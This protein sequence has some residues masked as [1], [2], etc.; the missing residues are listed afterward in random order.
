MAGWGRSTYNR[1]DQGS[2][3][4]T[5]V[6]TNILQE[7]RVPLLEHEE[8]DSKFEEDITEERLICAGGDPGE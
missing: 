1:W 2:L 3:Y 7:L 5:G 8:C 4:E 6:T